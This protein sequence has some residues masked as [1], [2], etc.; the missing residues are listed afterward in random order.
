[1]TIFSRTAAGLLA[2]FFA[3]LSVPPIV[4]AQDDAL[5]APALRISWEDFRALYD[6]G[7]IALIDVRDA[8]AFAA[9]HIPGA[10]SIPLPDVESKIAELRRLKN[11]IVLY[12]A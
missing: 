6:A 12:C 10:R 9:G 3:V 1:V 2:V 4:Q 7:R 8:D 5:A 11:P